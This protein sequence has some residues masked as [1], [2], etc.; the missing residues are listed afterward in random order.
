M[1]IG[2]IVLFIRTGGYMYPSLRTARVIRP[3]SGGR[4]IPVPI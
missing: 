2:R 1:G 3:P 4:D